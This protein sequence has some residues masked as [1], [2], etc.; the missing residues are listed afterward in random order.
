M[1][2]KLL[3]LVA[4]V[5]AFVAPS[6]E[7]MKKAGPI[8]AANVAN[9]SLD[10]ALRKAAGEKIDMKVEGQKLG[11]QTATVIAKTV[12]DEAER[13]LL[14]GEVYATAAEI[15]NESAVPPGIENKAL[16]VAGDA[17]IETVDV[18]TPSDPVKQ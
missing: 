10:L 8:I 15:I 17:L 7:T 16:I 4:L 18:L 13:K 2:N 14:T 5:A 9:Q 3:L 1:K 11:V 12:K 6:C